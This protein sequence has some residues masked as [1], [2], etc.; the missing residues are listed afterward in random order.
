MLELIKRYRLLLAGIGTFILIGLGYSIGQIS[1]GTQGVMLE[2]VTQEQ[3]DNKNADISN[4]LTEK[5]T[6]QQTN[7][8]TDC[9]SSDLEDKQPNT[10]NDSHL[11]TLLTESK[12]TTVASQPTTQTAESLVP[13]YICGEVQ[14]P[15][16]YYVKSTAI[17]NEVITLSGGFTA[18]ANQTAINLAS[19][20]I[21]N[22]KIVIP[23]IGEEIDKLADS[24]DNI[25][26]PEASL[27]TRPDHKVNQKQAL[28]NTSGININV[29]SQEQLMTLPGIG[30][31]KAAAIIAYREEVGGFSSKEE[32]KNV[33]GIGDK[34]YEKLESLITT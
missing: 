17:V 25:E 11:N 15:G 20:I 18:S 13:I 14:N 27:Q 32:L 6:L 26:R 29:A 21:A 5:Q 8:E 12:E 22:E 7:Q 16:V 24:Y 28:V 33:S 1:H 3:I 10:V 30:E 2:G 31:V 19:P 23:K 9:V 4:V 34:T